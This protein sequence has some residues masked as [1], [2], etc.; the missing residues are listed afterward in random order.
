MIRWCSSTKA[1]PKFL[2]L[3]K[4]LAA[5]DAELKAALQTVDNTALFKD[6]ACQIVVVGYASKTGN[7]VSNVKISKLRA[8]NV[9]RFLKG[10]VGHYADL[11]GDYGPTNVLDQSA[12][13]KNRAV[14]VYAGTL[15]PSSDMQANAEQFKRDFNREHGLH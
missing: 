5:E 12:D 13:E 10:I 11:C 15:E 4:S 8:S 3:G 14:E 1:R 2:A 7:P 9:N 6:P